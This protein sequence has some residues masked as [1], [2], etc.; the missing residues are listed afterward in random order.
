MKQRKSTSPVLSDFSH[1]RVLYGMSTLRIDK[2][3]S[4]GREMFVQSVK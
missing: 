4:V 2:Q 1:I 3:K